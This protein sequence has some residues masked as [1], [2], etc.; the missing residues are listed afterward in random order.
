MSILLSRFI[1]EHRTLAKL[2]NCTLGSICS[3]AKLRLS[4]QRYTLHGHWLQTS[5]ATGRLSIEE[6]NLQS[7]EHEVEFILTKMEIKKIWLLLTA[8]Y[9]QIELR[10]MA[11]FSRDSSLIA[12]LSQPEGD[13]FT[14]IAAK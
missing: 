6:P 2:L 5:T 4:T 1:K 8:D 11:H 9:S 12:Q 7:V 14:M 10:L 3:L 13:V